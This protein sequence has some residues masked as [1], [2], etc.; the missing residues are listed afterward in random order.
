MSTTKKE[1]ETLLAILWF[2]Y[3]WSILLRKN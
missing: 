1:L 2:S 3:I